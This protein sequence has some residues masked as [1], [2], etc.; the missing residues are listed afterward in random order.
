MLSVMV[1]YNDGWTW[2]RG[3]KSFRPYG[4]DVIVV[5]FQQI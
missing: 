5:T 4:A 1:E 2:D 3:S